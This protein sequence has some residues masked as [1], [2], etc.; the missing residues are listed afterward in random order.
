M[1]GGLGTETSGAAAVDEAGLLRPVDQVAVL[2]EVLSRLEASHA[3]HGVDEIE[4]GGAAVQVELV[5][6]RERTGHLQ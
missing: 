1:A 2:E 4:S 5:L 3:A 6:V